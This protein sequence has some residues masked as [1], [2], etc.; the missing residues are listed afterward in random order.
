MRLLILKEKK[1]E[2][3]S[4]ELSERNRIIDEL[5]ESKNSFSQSH[6][7]KDEELNLLQQSYNKVTV[8]LKE[9]RLKT[10]ELKKSL[11]E[12]EIALNVEKE[13]NKNNKA[14]NLTGNQ[15]NEEKIV[16]L[17]TQHAELQKLYQG[18]L[19]GIENL[20]AEIFSNQKKANQSTEKQNQEI[21]ELKTTISEKE[22][23]IERQKILIKEKDTQN[24]NKAQAEN[25]EIE[26][27]K[28]KLARLEE[29]LANSKLA[30]NELTKK[31][32]QADVERAEAIVTAE[33]LLLHVE[34]LEAKLQQIE[35]KK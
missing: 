31:N 24:E 35:E 28:S 25:E 20:K 26:K 15:Q 16:A 14:N 3:L 21:H 22:K 33:Q 9:E 30:V 29:E 7:V 8:E 19:V 18:S 17:E 1:N 11:K 23:E 13:T 2:S 5:N 32:E 12:L 27:L 6:H 10:E 34:S 4:H